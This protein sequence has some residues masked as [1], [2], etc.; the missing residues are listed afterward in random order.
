MDFFEHYTTT[1]A[2]AS[3]P[4][5]RLTSWTESY[6]RSLILPHL[7]QRRDVRLVD[8]GCGYGRYLYA[9]RRCGYTNV[10]GID[11]SDEQIR[12]AREV[13]GIA[14]VEKAD[15]LDYFRDTSA[16]YDVILLLDVIEHLELGAS[17]DLLR[18]LWGTLAAGGKLVIQVPNGLVPIPFVLY[19]D[20]THQRAYTP[21][22]LEQTLRLAGIPDWAHHALPPVVHGPV[23]FVR[24][25]VWSV[26]LSPLISVFMLIFAGATLH[27]I[28]TPNFLTVCHKPAR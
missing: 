18:R 25:A 19:G 6:F 23:S 5:K 4:E 17:V 12:Y 28:F 15:A 13:M 2:L 10:C 14:E 8:V 9:L 24:R 1:T 27:G 16:T 26:L 21:S 20:V 11:I 7:P 22:S 3:V